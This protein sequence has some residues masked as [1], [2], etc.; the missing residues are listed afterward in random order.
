MIFNLNK[1]AP[2]EAML[3]PP[4][5]FYSAITAACGSVVAFTAPHT[6][7][8][9]PSVGYGC[10]AFLLAFSGYR[11]KQGM[12]VRQYQKNLLRLKPFAMKTSEVPT[13]KNNLWIG[14]GFEW[15][16]KH[17]QR[18]WDCKR[19]DAEK[20]I[21]PSWLYNFA[22]EV[23]RRSEYNKLLQPIA[24]L[25]K[26]DIALNPVRKL[27][28][29]GG[30]TL[31]HGVEPN[32]KD[33]YSD[34]GERV[35]HTV[36]YGTTRVGKSRLAEVII[37]QDIARGDGSVICVDPKGDAGLMMRMY[38]EAKAAGRE[39][40]FYVMHLGFPDISARY[41]AVGSFSRISEVA[42]RISNQLG[43][44]GNSAAFKEF[45]W[46]F[47]N[48]VARALVELGQK[49]DYEQILKYIVDIEPLFIRYSETYLARQGKKTEGWQAIIG[50]KERSMKAPPPNMKGRSHRTC[51][52]ESYFTE[53]EIF[54]PVIMGLR[55]AVRYDKTYFDKLTASLLPLLE[56]L[57]SGRM[58][59]LISPDYLDV[60]DPRP[61]IDWMSVIRKKAI[62]Y[63]G[64]DAM[65]DGD[66]ASAVG[67]SMF[68][69]LVSTSGHLYKVGTEEGIIGGK[70]N[71]MP[72]IYLHADEFNELSGDEFVPL[73]NKAGGSGVH[74]TAY[75]QT[76]SD[77]EA[78]IGNAAKARQIEGN[79]NTII[80]LRVKTADTAE[81]LTNQ[82]PEVSI[83]QVTQ[84][85]GV[86][87]S[88]TPSDDV[89][90]T[91]KNEDRIS[92]VNV[93]MIEPSSIINLPKGQAFALVEGA[94]LL[95]LR[96]PLLEESD[97]SLPP[98]LKT[99]AERM[100]SNYRTSDAW[101][102]DVPNHVIRDDYGSD[103]SDTQ[104]EEAQNSTSEIEKMLT[105]DRLS[106]S[107]AENEQSDGKLS[108]LSE[109]ENDD[110]DWEKA[111]QSNE[112]KTTEKVE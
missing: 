86:N 25:T 10:G 74:V 103:E 50:A 98:N 68:S 38:A 52:L 104:I 2:I 101:W 23:E 67:N 13:S 61:I 49:P 47:I 12:T 48:I 26:L 80:M 82:L 91:S 72:K 70:A 40:D 64:L 66:V 79:F 84:V 53:H 76:R 57:T 56:K 71:E 111:L 29:L 89:H 60:K 93:P 97:T 110:I 65:T 85:S 31:I 5:E 27:P 51:A 90:F 59:E 37:T 96:F 87:D 1:D 39:D 3:R 24:S 28:P 94:K 20:Y 16:Q 88:S 107:G 4:V 44:E 100:K 62:V 77:L 17:T 92:T 102:N 58:A 6:I 30:S 99:M 43:A 106:N 34:L 81:L 11:F 46:R 41:N 35:G 21:Q 108:K 78:R 45:A 55:S 69:D 8:M 83:N 36:V 9:T 19:S 15:R 7:M 95:K 112:I 42:S 105:D 32:E 75:T 54:D 73:L 33:Q 18:L 109:Q 63:I 14:K 22:R